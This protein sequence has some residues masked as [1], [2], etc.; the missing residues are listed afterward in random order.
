MGK[1]KLGVAVA[2]ERLSRTY[3]EV[4]LGSI[5]GTFLHGVIKQRIL[6]QPGR[7]MGV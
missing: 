6:R 1:A 5:F 3:G 7:K 4:D 2:N